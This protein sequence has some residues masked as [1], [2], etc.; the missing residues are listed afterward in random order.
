MIKSLFILW[1][2][3]VMLQDMGF[4]VEGIFRLCFIIFSIG[5]VI[6]LLVYL[7]YLWVPF[8]YI[9]IYLI[10]FIIA[11]YVIKMEF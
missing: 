8:I 2:L 1:L 5:S 10:G 6:V 3:Y 11:C 4:D 7:V 9:Y